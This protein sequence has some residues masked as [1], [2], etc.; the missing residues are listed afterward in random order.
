[1]AIAVK[2]KCNQGSRK[3]V[4][5]SCSSIVLATL[6]EDRLISCSMGRVCRRITAVGYEGLAVALITRIFS[7]KALLVDL[8]QP[9]AQALTYQRCESIQ[10]RKQK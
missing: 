5:P 6:W 9:A 1:M 3:A 8:S 2:A 4:R 7:I 10:E